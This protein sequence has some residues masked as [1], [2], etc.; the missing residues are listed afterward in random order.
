M[1]GIAYKIN[2]EPRL[3]WPAV[4]DVLDGDGNPTGETATNLEQLIAALPEGIEL[5]DESE[6]EAWWAANLPA[7]GPDVQIAKIKAELDRLDL[8]SIR[9]LRAISNGTDID[10]DHQKLVE[11]EARV[12]ELRVELVE[13]IG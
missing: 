9:P 10:S 4:T 3:T 11:V 8:A 7:P 5:I 6:A 12:A 2:G 1:Q 13:L